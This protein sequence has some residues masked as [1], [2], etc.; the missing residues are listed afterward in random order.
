MPQSNAEVI[1]ELLGAYDR[2]DTDAFFAKLDPEVEFV[3]A[4]DYPGASTH[5]G[6]EGVRRAL[7]GWREAWG[8]IRLELEE[9]VEL[10]DRMLTVGR[11]HVRAEFSGVGFQAPLATLWTLREGRVARAQFFLDPDEAHAAMGLD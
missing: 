11:Q 1:R 9:V 2:G 3:E 4:A 7:E 6:R 10:G 8:E 5:H